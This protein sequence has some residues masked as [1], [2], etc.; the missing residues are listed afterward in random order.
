[1]YMHENDKFHIP[2]YIQQMSI[3]EIRKERH[4]ILMELGKEHIKDLDRYFFIVSDTYGEKVIY[5]TGNIFFNDCATD[6]PDC[7]R[8]NE[9]CGMKLSLTEL[10]QLIEDDNFFEYIYERV[11]YIGNL[12]EEEAYESCMIYYSGTPGTELHISEVTN[13]TPCGN[14]WF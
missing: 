10:Q 6:T 8:I 2:D 9:W 13:D 14:Y 7:Y 4:R 5:I 12:T 3:A 11:D 1:M